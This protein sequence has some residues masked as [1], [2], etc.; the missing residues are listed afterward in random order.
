MFNEGGS[1]SPAWT[2]TNAY[3]AHFNATLTFP[4]YR[5]LGF[6]IGASDDY[7]N[8]APATFKKNS[9]NFTTGITYTFKQP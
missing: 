9:S 4:V 5:G 7:L 8:N 1:I 6:N 2:D 3:S